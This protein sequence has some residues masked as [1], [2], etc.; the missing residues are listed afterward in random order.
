MRMETIFTQ[1]NYITITEN[2]AGMAFFI[3]YREVA[4]KI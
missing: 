1:N 2:K 3:V 4:A